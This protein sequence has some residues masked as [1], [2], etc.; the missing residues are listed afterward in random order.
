MNLLHG[1]KNIN[2][3]YLFKKL[4]YLLPIKTQIIIRGLYHLGYYL[5]LNHPKTFNEKI[6]ARK[7]DKVNDLFVICSDKAAVRKY[8]ADKIGEEYLIPLIYVGSTITVEQLKKFG[9]G[10]VAK[11]THD[12]GNV[13]LITDSNQNYQEICSALL[14]HFDHDFGKRT[15]ENWYSK[16]SPQIIVEKLLVKKNGEIPEDYKFHVFNKNGKFKVI[17]QIDYDRFTDHNR[18]FYDENLKLLPFSIKYKNYQ[19]EI[20]IPPKNFDR[21]IDLSKKLSSEFEY[22]RVDF[23]NVDG[24]IYFG[25]LTFAHGSGFEDFLPKKYDLIIGQEW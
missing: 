19:K 7:L 9:I 22:V 20:T 14:G 1:I 24:D 8:V 4:V 5:D 12:S 11:T 3:K 2:M 16:I 10:I 18:S 15:H 6:Q 23:Y 17:L 25:E 21:M 13:H